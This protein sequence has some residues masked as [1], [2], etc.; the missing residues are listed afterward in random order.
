[1]TDC[2][3]RLTF[4]LPTTDNC[5]CVS[6]LISG[7][8]HGS[9]IGW[10]VR[11]LQVIVN[12]GLQQNDT[13]AGGKHAYCPIIT[14]QPKQYGSPTRG[15][16]LQNL[17]VHSVAPTAVSGVD[18]HAGGVGMG[19]AIAMTG[20][21]H[22]IKNCTITHL[23]DCGSNVTPLLAMGSTRTIVSGSSFHFGCTLYAMHS[24]KSLLW[25]GN[26]ASNL[27]NLGRDGSVIGTFGSPY[28]VEHISFFGNVQIDNGENPPG[29]IPIAKGGSCDALPVTKCASHRLETLTLDGG[30][31]AYTGHVTKAIG[32]E[33]TLTTNPFLNG[34][35][36]YQPHADMVQ[37]SWAGSAA[38]I[39]S[40]TGAGQ[41]RHVTQ[42]RGR[43]W[44]VDR[45]W[46]VAPDATSL[47]QIS[48]QRG[49]I[50]LVGNKWTDGFTVQLYA[51]CLSA[52]V[53]E[54]T[55]DHTPL[56]SWGRNPHA[57][58]YQPNW[59]VEL[60]G[61]L[62]PNSAGLTVQTS[63]QDVPG[64]FSWLYN[65]PLGSGIAIRRNW[66]NGSGI[67]V[68]GTASD[69][70]VEGNSVS[71]KGSRAGFEPIDVANTTQQILLRGNTLF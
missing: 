28:I 66:I 16:L 56:I 54:N 25:E 10:T 19:P 39:M 68:H 47:L 52:V 29:I 26:T 3:T 53:A 32:L 24:V 48:P 7:P 51:Q 31:G 67:V 20:S 38:M 71:K 14:T 45:P 8:D 30:G 13:V 34:S 37:A 36:S 41:W 4:C 57:W 49:H 58:G 15:M 62:H 35:G 33:L 17:I 50:L 2:K 9:T 27:T 55:L 64:N 70:L 63:D 43:V 46:V 69:V 6:G 21:D 60:L 44:S 59:R 1:M 22:A 18:M 23:G 40:G 42:H 11:D 61:N 5:N 12:G 65:G